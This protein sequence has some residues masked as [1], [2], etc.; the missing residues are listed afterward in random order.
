MTNLKLLNVSHNKVGV[1]DLFAFEGLSELKTLDLSYNVLR[2]FQDAW[3]ISLSQLQEL[4][5]KGNML[6]SINMEPKLN[7]K[8]LQVSIIRLVVLQLISFR[9]MRNRNIPAFI[10]FYFRYWILVTLT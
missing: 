7:F 6:T 8:N 9:K 5:L 3:F 1:I 2:Y 10:L 4:Y